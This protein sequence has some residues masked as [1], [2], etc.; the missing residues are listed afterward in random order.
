MDPI[1]FQLENYDASGAW[2]ERDGAFAIDANGPA[3][4]RRTLAAKRDAF[5]HNFSE[6]L[7]TYALGRGVEPADRAA[8]DQ[9]KQSAAAQE[10]R[11]SALV[12]AIVKNPVFLRGAP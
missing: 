12:L 2:R 8:L 5:Y 7:L 9:I 10:H 1:G 11:F 6:K 3:E 4:L